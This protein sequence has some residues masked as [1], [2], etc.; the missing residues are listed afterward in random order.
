MPKF[1]GSGYR[2]WV[3]TSGTYNEVKGQSDLS[4]S[5]QRA[6]IDASDKQSYPAKVYLAGELDGSI[7]MTIKPDYPD[8]GGCQR[9]ETLFKAGTAE[10]YQIRRNGSA[11]NGTTDVV[12]QQSMIISQMSPNKN[13]GELVSFSVVLMPAAAATIDTFA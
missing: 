4:R 2:L 10:L 6:M 12:F 13:K 7:A 3:N 11:G 9:M 5:S 1:D 8:S